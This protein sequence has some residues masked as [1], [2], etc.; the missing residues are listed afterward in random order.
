[1]WTIII[2]QSKYTICEYIAPDIRISLFVYSK[3]TSNMAAWFYAH[4]NDV[5][6]TA[7]RYADHDSYSYGTDAEII[8]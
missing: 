4:F 3:Y 1:V 6:A 2:K 5:N 7:F 8:R